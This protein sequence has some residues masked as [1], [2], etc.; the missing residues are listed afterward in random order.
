MVWQDVNVTE[1][2]ITMHLSEADLHR[3][4]QF[5]NDAHFHSGGIAFNLPIHTQAVERAVKE[6]TKSSQQV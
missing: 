6:A 2:L 1:P 3:M 5:I 4:L